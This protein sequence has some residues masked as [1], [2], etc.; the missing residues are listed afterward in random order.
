M[1]DL[2]IFSQ[3]EKKETWI[4][5]K[6][7]EKFIPVIWAILLTVWI[8]Y[9]L[10]TNIWLALDETE[11][12]GLWF[13]ASFAIIWWATFLPNKYRYLSD[14]VIWIGVLL[15]YWTL[16]YGSRD[17]NLENIIIPEVATLISSFIF[18]AI[19]SF[20]ASARKSK[21]I[22]ILWMLWAYL[23]P[24]VIWQ[25]WSWVQNISFNA[26]LIYFASV[27]IVTFQL[28]KEINIRN[29]IPLNILW[30]FFGT[31]SLYYVSYYGSQVGNSF[32]TWD[33][34]SIGLF[35]VLAVFSIFSIIISSKEFEEND[36]GY[37]AFWYIATVLWFILNA[38]LL[39]QIPDFITSV[40]YILLSWVCFYWWYFL[41]NTKTRYQHTALYSMW[42]LTWVAAFFSLIPE[43]NVYTSIIISYSSLIFAGLY[44]KDT[45][46][47][48]KNNDLWII[49]IYLSN[50]IRF[51][52]LWYLK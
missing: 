49:S 7:I 1:E 51:T 50:V 42:V 34:L 25:N 4:M 22:L 48:E 24:F 27:N 41:K 16:I 37:I 11:K 32:F 43:L 15:L 38:N 3:E 21:V 31:S 23:T 39:N 40:F 35:F 33:L 26:F 30:L 47:D 29:I 10:Y 45:S 13:V 2:N 18:T 12:L 8:G 46:K 19:I 44:L 52:Y 6:I 5:D 17:D 9:L 28:G 36:E 20:F 14:V